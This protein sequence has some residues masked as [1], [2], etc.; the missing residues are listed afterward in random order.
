MLCKD[1]DLTRL[2]LFDSE[3]KGTMIPENISRYL[4]VDM[5]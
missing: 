3:D 1:V 4:P 2:G 5:V